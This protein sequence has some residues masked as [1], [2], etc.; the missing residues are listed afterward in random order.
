MRLQQQTGCSYLEHHTL[1]DSLV[2]HLAGLVMAQVEQGDGGAVWISAG[3]DG[4]FAKAELRLERPR[5]VVKVCQPFPYPA[6]KSL[7]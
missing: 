6:M 5:A 7:T 2:R 1:Q 3:Q 4:E